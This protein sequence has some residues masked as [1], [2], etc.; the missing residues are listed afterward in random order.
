[1]SKLQ[2][3]KVSSTNYANEAAL[4][5]G[6]P[7]AAAMKLLG[8][9]WKPMIVWYVHHGLRRFGDLRRTI[10]NVSEKMLYQQL[11]E[12]QRD[13]LLVR[14]AHGPRRV[15]YELT[16][17]AVSLVPTLQAL[18]DWSERNHIGQRLL[19]VDRLPATG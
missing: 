18:A 10:P 5:A 11:R 15:S 2:Q 16:G 7:L 8:G 17:L 1:M 6:C 9:R 12:L 19:R 4:I 13:G 3:R 14:V